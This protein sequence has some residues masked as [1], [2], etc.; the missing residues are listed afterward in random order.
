MA[1]LRQT[2][3]TGRALSL[4]ALFSCAA[5][6][7]IFDGSVAASTCPSPAFTPGPAAIV[8]NGPANFV[9]GDLDKNGTLDFAV[10]NRNSHSVSIRLGNGA[11]GFPSGSDVDLTTAGDLPTGIA[12]GDLDGDPYPD[13]A[14]TAQSTGRVRFLQGGAGGTFTALPQANDLIGHNTPLGVA[15]ADFNRDGRTDLVVASNGGN[16]SLVTFYL[17]SAGFT[18]GAGQVVNVGLGASAVVVGDFDRDGDPDVAVLNS[19]SENVSVLLNNGS[20]VFTEFGGPTRFPV[21]AGS[22]PQWMAS[23]DFDRDGI[24]DLV[25]ANTLANTIT[26]L[27]GNGVGFFSSVLT[28]PTLSLP[29]WVTVADFDRDGEADLAVAEN[30]A[31]M[32]SVR[33]GTTGFAF[34]S[35]NDFP[36][37]APLGLAAGDFNR[38]GKVDLLRTVNASNTIEVSL[39]D[40]GFACA[41][42][43]FAAARAFDAG[44]SP[45][46]IVKGDFDNDGRLDLAVSNDLAATPDAVSLLRGSGPGRFDPPLVTGTGAGTSVA[47]RMAAGDFDGD[48]KLDVVTANNGSNNVS[49]LP[50]TGGAFG[51]PIVLGGGSG[52]AGV[53]VGDF[54]ND[55][56]LDFAVS[57]NTGGDIWVYSKTGPGF[58]F[59]VPSVHPVGAGLTSLATGDL[60]GDGLLDLVAGLGSPSPNRVAVLLG[61]VAGGFGG[62]TLYPVSGTLPKGIVVADLNNDG[63]LDVAT[64]NWSSNSASIFQGNG[65]GALAEV[66]VAGVGTR[67]EMIVAEDFNDDGTLDLATANSQGGGTVTVL[68][69]AGTFSYGATTYPSAPGAFGIAAADFTGDGQI[70]LVTTNASGDMV[71]LFVG[72][73]AGAFTAARSVFTPG[74]IADAAEPGDFNR[75]G[76]LDLAVANATGGSVRVLV[77]DGTG[78]FPASATTTM[79]G[80]IQ[81]A[82]PADFDRDGMLDVVVANITADTVQIWKGNGAGN[83]TSYG[84][85]AFALS[86]PGHLAVGDFNRDGKVDVAAALGSGDVATYLQ[87]T[88]PNPLGTSPFYQ[89]SAG[90]SPSAVVAGDFDG[91]GILDLAVANQGSGTV[92]VRAGAGDGTFPTVLDTPATGGSPAHLVAGDFDR[93]GDVDLVTAN[94]GS[95]DVTFLRNSGAGLFPT[96][97]TSV[98]WGRPIWI[99]AGDFNRD[100]LLDVATTSVNTATVSVL[101]GDGTGSFA[102]L[103]TYGIAGNTAGLATG[104]FDRDGD[105][106]LVSANGLGFSMSFVASTNCASRRFEVVQWPLAC[107]SPSPAFLSIQPRLRLTDDGDNL[108]QCDAQQVTASIATGGGALSGSTIQSALGGTVSY[109]NLSV[110]PAGVHYRLG[111]TRSGA[112]PP[113]PARTP[114][115]TVGLTVGVNGPATVCSGSSSAWSVLAPPFVIPPVYDKYLWSLGGTPLGSASTLTLPAQSPG[116]FVLQLDATLDGCTAT[117]TTPFTAESPVG[118][119]I[120]V[121][122]GSTTVCTS[123]SGA[124]VGA[125]E[126]GGGTITGRQWGYRTTSG[127][128]ITSIPGMTLSSYTIQA[129]HFQGGTPGLYHLVETSS[130]VCG[131]PATSNEIPVIVYGTTAAPAS[132]VFTVTSTNKQNVLE[133]LNP[134]GPFFGTLVQYNKS[135]T[136]TS[137]CAFPATPGDGTTLTSQLGGGPGSRDSKLHDTLEND[138]AYCYTAF[139][140][141]AP[142]TY[143][144]PGHAIKARPFDNTLGFVKWAL[145]TGSTSLSPPGMGQNVI[146]VVANDGAVHAIKKGAG[147]GTWADAPWKPPLLPLPSQTGRPGAVPVPVGGQNPVMFLSSQDGHLYSFGAANGSAAWAAPP[148]LGDAV[149]SPP[150]GV[151]TAF[152][153]TADLLFVGTRNSGTANSFYALRLA[154]GAPAWVFTGGG[155][156]RIG[157]I[158]GQAAVDYTTGRVYFASWEFSPTAPDNHTLWCVGFSGDLCGG[159]WPRAYG[160]I[161]G[162]VTMRG[163]TLYV[164]L[165]GGG[166]RAIDAATG[167]SNWLVPYST[168]G[169][170]KGFV[171]PDRLT[172]D[173]YFSTSSTIYSVSDLLGTAAFP[174]WGL[175]FPNASTPVFIPNDDKVYVGGNNALFRRKQSDGSPLDDFA[176]GDP[177]VPSVVGSPTVDVRDGFVY[178]GTDA[179]VVYAIRIP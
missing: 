133:W 92:T 108:V 166:V 145:S 85:A 69:A 39:N 105:A 20:G 125:A 128:P 134:S 43:S 72:T 68:V 122:T 148:P 21:G 87:G 165:D 79:G 164:G 80:N 170:V 31:N 118:V 8:Q 78:A 100:G 50:G 173:L 157:V 163:G 53:A 38:D 146:H 167:A 136:G 81:H 132:L 70:D 56:K 149:Q 141:T 49:I 71:L 174:N 26:L 107:N 93:D 112:N 103:V 140:A 144:V 24:I 65:A 91:D 99:V 178:V 37:A 74:L 175:P 106:D 142:F 137:N 95:K 40:A 101:V 123:C 120:G 25:T 54:N 64:T 84:S 88:L 45:L 150:S 109:G 42:S 48:G 179:G 114:K 90:A 124:T 23:G 46:A 41:A 126:T 58:S 19:V 33:L 22:G 162:G 59:S 75:D 177:A 111:F 47:A 117:K 96:S 6:W 55:G 129:G 152:G 29:V 82:V 89:F 27:R 159:G 110:S 76:I 5:L 28:L 153:G 155:A 9:T 1:S 44:A 2:A 168:S 62:A 3:P 67:P 116:G 10:T 147:G 102:P 30:G 161:S 16:P 66:F 169:T 113:I 60:N 52:P 156:G 135:A 172:D 12:V 160:N 115:F 158:N 151:F 83:L 35:S 138:T 18:F 130:A 139:V 51:S 119:T 171:Y 98:V 63:F 104:D 7:S 57:N 94:N 34:G 15:A 127:G 154:D 32:V 77:G 4:A 86:D 61:Q 131:G 97:T 176:L 14:I 121:A 36:A 143:S 73:G 11:G 17:R 13:L